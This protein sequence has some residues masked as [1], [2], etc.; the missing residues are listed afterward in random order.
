MFYNHPL[1]L[2]ADLLLV[3]IMTAFVYVAWHFNKQFKG[4]REWFL[5]FACA[6]SNLLL[7]I[8]RPPIPQI[9][10]SIVLQTLLMSTGLF[11]LYGCRLYVDKKIS[12]SKTYLFIILPTIAVATYF[13]ELQ[14]N[15]HVGFLITSLITGCFFIA[16]G[17]SLQK[18]GMKSHPIRYALSVAL[19]LHGVFMILRPG[20]FTPIIENLLKQ[21]FSIS[22]FEFILFQQILFTPIFALSTILLV[23]ED[24]SHQLRIQAEYDSLTCL[25]NRGS[26][27]S[28]L[29][30]AANLSS[31]LKTPLTIL[32]I[33]LD[34]F[35]AINDQ[36]GHQAGDEVLKS[37]SRIAEQCI[38]NVDGIGRIGGEEFSIYLMN[39]PID[40]AKIIAERLRNL[41]E[42]TPVKLPYGQIYYSASIGIA[43]YDEKMG[44]DNV[45]DIADR[46]LYQ[47]KQ[48]G[49]NRVELANNSGLLAQNC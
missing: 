48:K 17:L 32:T 24:N 10:L 5:A 29:R 40:S 19:L 7:F 11:A 13:A 47:A 36:Y 43:G 2:A 34:H 21:L 33:D 38:R 23:N 9:T 42:K 49:R 39:T 37:F 18:E 22:G 14:S 45:I 6:T 25:R 27:F 46:A 12:V 31:R 16:G 15:P 26:F 1:L 3:M 30:K 28:Q 35:K 20:L 8:L 4:M 44:I 41:I